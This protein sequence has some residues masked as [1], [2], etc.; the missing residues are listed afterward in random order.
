MTTEGSVN[1]TVK[2][3]LAMLE[4]TL[5]EQIDKIG[6]RIEE[7]NR[8][9]DLRASTTSVEALEKRISRAEQ[10]II[11]MRV[12]NAP[13]AAM[14][15]LQMGMFAL[16]ITGVFGLIAALFYVVAANGGHG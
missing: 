1:Y 2:E 14:S 8:K 11:D 3:L 13:Q 16:V 4:K 6:V 9:L 10:A 7:V 12:L 15:K 5:T